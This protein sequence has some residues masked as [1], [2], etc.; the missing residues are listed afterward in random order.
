M[1]INTTWFKD[2]LLEKQLSQRGLAKLMGLDSAAVSLML[3][4]KRQMRIGEATQIATFLGVSA[5]E[6]IAHVG[7]ALDGPSPVPIIGVITGTTARVKWG[8]GLGEVPR[9]IGDLPLRCAAIQCR[10]AGTPLDY[11]NRWVLFVQ[12]PHDT[13]EIKPEC[14][15][16]LS[17]VRPAGGE[18]MIAVVTRG[19]APGRWNLRGPV[20]TA[21]E[22]ELEYASPVL[23]ITT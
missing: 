9:P 12:E 6:V 3:R 10:T 1:T 21:E 5:E 8:D 4:G 23:L 16:R 19:Y 2:K 17:L 15:D 22:T 13:G 20:V 7:G 18:S 11:M 14:I